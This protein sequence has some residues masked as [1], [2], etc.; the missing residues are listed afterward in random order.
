M[1]RA[2]AV[3]IIELARVKVPTVSTLGGE[4]AQKTADE[5]P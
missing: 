4:N 2:V 3:I 1:I 5:L